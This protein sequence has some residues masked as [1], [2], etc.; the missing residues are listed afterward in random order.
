M[1]SSL[2]GSL[3]YHKNNKKPN[4]FVLNSGSSVVINSGE[5]DKNIGYKSYKLIN[6]NNKAAQEQLDLQD[7]AEIE[8]F[9]KEESGLEPLDTIIKRPSTQTVESCTTQED[10]QPSFQE[11]LL[12]ALSHFDQNPQIFQF[13]EKPLVS[14]ELEQQES[15]Q[16]QSTRMTSKHVDETLLKENSSLRL[17]IKDLHLKSN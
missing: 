4:N 8:Q 5:G 2:T 6:N 17:M 9:Q 11:T 15:I 12:S 7:K 14:G 10:S 1:N 16:C 3:G 13:K